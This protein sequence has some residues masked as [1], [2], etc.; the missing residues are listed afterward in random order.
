MTSTDLTLRPT[1]DS[2]VIAV[3]E[4]LELGEP[5]VAPAPAGPQPPNRVA[6]RTDEQ[7]LVLPAVADRVRLWRILPGFRGAVLLASRDHNRL[8][9]YSRFDAGVGTAPTV[10]EPGD[11][12]DVPAR[13]L[14]RRA[15][16]LVWRDGNENPTVISP[17]HTPVVHF[18][19]FTVLDDRADALLD[20]VAATA[21]AALATPGLRTVNFHRSHDGQR[22]INVGTWSGFDQFH[23]LLAQPG[24][25]TGEKYWEGL[26]TFENDYFDVVGVVSGQERAVAR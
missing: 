12:L 6:R 23:L 26:A 10:L 4:R 21:P 22:L 5:E 7:A 11:P 3:V 9:V 2:N 13:V 19:L 20:R 8:A 18:G 15:Y 25:K 16:D 1:R 24:F 17:R 14:D